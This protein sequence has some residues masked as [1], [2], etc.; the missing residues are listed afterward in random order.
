MDAREEPAPLGLPDFSV[1]SPGAQKSGVF[2]Y[3]LVSL[4]E[5]SKPLLETKD[6]D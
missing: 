3:H 5:T 1:K 6:V 2:W 4:D